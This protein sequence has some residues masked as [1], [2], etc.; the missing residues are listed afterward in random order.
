MQF[1]AAILAMVT[2]RTHIDL[3]SLPHSG[4]A[5]NSRIPKNGYT[6]HR[7]ERELKIVHKSWALFKE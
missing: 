3:D 6:K 7:N 5:S 1:I 2:G 4:K